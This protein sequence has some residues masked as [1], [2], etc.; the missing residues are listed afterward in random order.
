M[1]KRNNFTNYISYFFVLLSLF[2]LSCSQADTL[3]QEVPDE[4]IIVGNPTWNNG[5]GE[6]MQNKCGTCHDVPQSEYIP[7]N[8]PEYLNLN[9]YSGNNNTVFGADTIAVWIQ[10]GILEKSISSIRKM[11]LNYATPLTNN[12]ISYLKEWVSNGS[13]E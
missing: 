9:I 1:T 4:T 5:I 11:P 3:G 7:N 13:P 6:I 8:T 2:S 10:V 12:E